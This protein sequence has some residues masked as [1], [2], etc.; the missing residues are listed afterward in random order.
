M[1]I[2]VKLQNW[3]KR[4][5]NLAPFRVGGRQWNATWND[6][7]QAYLFDTPTLDEVNNC[8]RE[9]KAPHIQLGI[10]LEE[11]AVKPVVIASAPVSVPEKEPD[12]VAKVL[13]VPKANRLRK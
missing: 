1:K 4:G 6:K 8:L 9:V 5:D 11:E 13:E 12:P 7:A 3:T 10:Y 2:Y